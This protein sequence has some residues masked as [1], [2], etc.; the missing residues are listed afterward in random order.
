MGGGRSYLDIALE[1]A[2][3]ARG[4]LA[5]ENDDLRKLVVGFTNGLQQVVQSTRARLDE[6][7]MDCEVRSFGYHSLSF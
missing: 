3:S 1:D 6:N 7:A 5:E 2:E 4:R